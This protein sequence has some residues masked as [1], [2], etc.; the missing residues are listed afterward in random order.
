MRNSPIALRTTP[1][2]LMVAI[3]LAIAAWA[4]VTAFTDWHPGAAIGI[5]IVVALLAVLSIQGSTLV[6]WIARTRRVTHHSRPVTITSRDGAA[7]VWDAHNALASCW[8]DITPAGQWPLT[9]VTSQGETSQPLVDLDMLAEMMRQDDIIVHRLAL[10]TSGTRQATASRPARIIS[11][12]VGATPTH[13]S[14]RTLLEVTV[15]MSESNAAAA[16]RATQGSYVIGIQKT[17]LAAAARIVIRLKAQGLNAWI[18]GPGAVRNAA[19][20]ILNHVGAASEHQAWKQL[21]G[22]GSTPAVVT[23]TPAGGRWDSAQQHEWLKTRTAHTFEHTFLERSPSGAPQVAHLVSFVSPDSDTQIDGID[24]NVGLNV[25]GGQ[26]AQAITRYMPLA[27]SADLDVPQVPLDEQMQL[28]THAGGLGVF[29]GTSPEDGKVFIRLDGNNTDPLWIIGPELLWRQ[30]LQRVSLTD[31]TVDLQLDDPDG[32]WQ[33][34]VDHLDAP[35]ITCGTNPDAAVIVTGEG[36]PHRPRQGQ[37]HIILT[38]TTPD[39]APQ[40]CVVA[41]ADQELVAISGATS[42][43]MPWAMPGAE[44]DLLDA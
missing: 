32:R 18:L 7:V 6:E 40:Y 4:L 11:Q 17:V 31:V 44:R 15:K 10:T 24:R 43:T 14:A 5:A 27:A 25:L 21:G 35:L 29:L 16:A 39:P 26:Q 12:V 8:I 23:A 2:Y 37:S 20:D 30:F 38:T 34:F 9:A 42:A 1:G 36:T 13:T 33:A 19:T 28:E 22:P 41:T 3:A